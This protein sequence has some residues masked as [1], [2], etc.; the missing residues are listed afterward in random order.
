VEA[1]AVLEAATEARVAVA[2]PDPIVRMALAHCQF[3]AIHPFS[4]GNGRTGRIL[5]ILL[6]VDAGLLRTPILYLSRYIIDHKQD[7][8]RPLAD[9]TREAAWDEWTL[10]MVEAVR[11][12]A[13]GTLAKIDAIE[14]LT[15][16][17]ADE[18]ADVTPGLRHAGFLSV[19]FSQPYARIGDVMDRCGVSR[20][21]A[22]G[23]LNELVAAGMLTDVKVGR[24]R[25]FLNTS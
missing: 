17:F 7:D 18:A 11:S 14:S 21:T 9:V 20:P 6:L 3:E 4:D 13:E 5:N 23:W 12:S 19:L 8:H 16:R 2:H 24:D 1:K 10:Y 22:A 25:L 15:A